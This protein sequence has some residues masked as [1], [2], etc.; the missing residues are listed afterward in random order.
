MIERYIQVQ[1]KVLVYRHV[2]LQHRLRAAQSTRTG[3]A[4]TITDA[5]QTQTTS[6]CNK[7]CNWPDTAAQHRQLLNRH[8]QEST[9]CYRT[10]RSEAANAAVGGTRPE[11]AQSDMS[12]G[13]TACG[14][15]GMSIVQ[16]QHRLLKDK[17]KLMLLQ[18]RH[19]QGQHRLLQTRH[20]QGIA[21]C[22]IDTSRSITGCIRLIQPSNE[23][24]KI[25]LCVNPIT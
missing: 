5:A 18:K 19:I 22:R 3:A 21:G 2:K 8:V 4:E 24:E 9:G 7:S 10:E 1:C 13:S 17:K 12:R 20:V 15:T 14:R 11:T 23:H 6:R 16:R 25:V